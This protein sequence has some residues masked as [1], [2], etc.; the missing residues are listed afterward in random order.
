MPKFTIYIYIYIYRERERE[1]YRER[2]LRFKLPIFIT[3]SDIT[4]PNNLLF[5][6]YFKNLTIRL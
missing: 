3:L 6:L 1:I 2:E 4:Q 5:N